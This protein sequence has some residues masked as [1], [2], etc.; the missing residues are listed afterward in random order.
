MYSEDSM[1][2]FGISLVVAA[3]GLATVSAAAARD[4]SGFLEPAENPLLGTWLLS[5]EGINPNLPIR[6]GMLHMSFTQSPRTYMQFGPNAVAVGQRI[7]TILDHDHVLI[8]E[9]PRCTYQRGP[10][11]GTTPLLESIKAEEEAKQRSAAEPPLPPPH[12][13]TREEV[14]RQI[15]EMAHPSLP[16]RLTYDEAIREIEK[17]PAA[18][19]EPPAAPAPV[20]TS[21]E[22]QR[23]MRQLDQAIRE[24]QERARQQAPP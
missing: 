8:A 17:L 22:L 1:S 11:D 23:S 20:A 12:T 16:H 9:I 4:K 13:P 7:Y 15:D 24:L 2:P 6:C 5:A 18:E 14:E 19:A 3:L 10:L 21:P